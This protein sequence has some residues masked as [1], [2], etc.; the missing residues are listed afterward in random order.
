MHQDTGGL[1]VAGHTAVVT[2]M[3]LGHPTQR[4]LR[5]MVV[6]GGGKEKR[7]APDWVL[8]AFR[9]RESQAKNNR[10]SP[11]WLVMFIP[12][13]KLIIL[14]SWYQKRNAAVS[15]LCTTRHIRRSVESGVRYRMDGPIISARASGNN[16]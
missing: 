5:V 13:S 3:L 2:R 12:V 15:V 10:H 8:V 9:E 4:Q 14:S 7:K 1:R 16:G 6:C 11:A